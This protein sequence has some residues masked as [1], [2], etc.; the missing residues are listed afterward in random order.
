MLKSELRSGMLIVKPN[1]NKGIVMLNT[2]NGDVIVGTGV[3]DGETWFPMKELEEDLNNHIEGS[4]YNVSQV[5]SYSSNK[6][7]ANMSIS[8]RSLLWSK[9]STKVQLGDYTGI[10]EDGV[11]KI[12]GGR[13]SKADLQKLLSNI[14]SIGKYTM[15]TRAGSTINHMAYEALVDNGMCI[16]SKVKIVGTHLG[17]INGFDASWVTLMD[18]YVG[19][20]VKV[21]GV[22][23]TSEGC[24]IKVEN[25]NGWY[26]PPAVLEL[27]EKT[28]L[29]DILGHQ[30]S[31]DAKTSEIKV[32]C[33]TYKVSELE[34]VL[35]KF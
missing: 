35:S 18:S 15:P 6:T 24:A 5:Y 12:A 17:R 30:V 21:T 28:S 29:P 20:T 1:G 26:F 14:I 25:S 33:Q 34:M 3:D 31:F 7:A 10:I 13:I 19:K 32:G 16:G 8:N 9:S 27:V 4:G 11:L 23:N 22:S 2:P